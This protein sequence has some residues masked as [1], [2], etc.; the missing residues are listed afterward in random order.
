MRPRS[1][2][3]HVPGVFS[4][5]CLIIPAE[6]ARC[7]PR[8]ARM[9]P[10]NIVRA[11]VGT[12]NPPS[13]TP[14][15]YSRSAPS[16]PHSDPKSPAGSPDLHPLHHQIPILRRSIQVVGQRQADLV[17]A[18]RHLS[19]QQQRVRCGANKV[20]V[21]HRLAVDA[22]CHVRQHPPCAGVPLARMRN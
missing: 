5:S 4:Q 2:V 22:Q 16:P 7:R 8:S 10:L 12:S 11:G 19:F 6:P 9:L 3:L 14:D 15:P 20:R 13:D 21:A 18:G 17:L 1:S